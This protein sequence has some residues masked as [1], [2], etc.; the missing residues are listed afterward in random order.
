MTRQT[1]TQTF[2]STLLTTCC[3]ALAACLTVAVAPAHASGDHGHGNNPVLDEV[4]HH[5][6]QSWAAYEAGEMD[7]AAEELRTAGA[8]VRLQSQRIESRLGEEADPA[9]RRELRD[10]RRELRQAEEAITSMARDLGWFGAPAA[11]DLEE[12]FVDT[13]YTLAG[14]HHRRAAEALELGQRARA[15]LHLRMVADYM[16]QGAR[17]TGRAVDEAAPVAAET[18]RVADSLEHENQI[19]RESK[20]AASASLQATGQVIQRLPH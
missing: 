11:E 14:Y 12:V 10:E 6:D 19:T 15:A 16:E 7:Q 5:F 2:R 20:A 8:Y 4:N 18:R 17:L 9:M 3:C 1:A 13:N